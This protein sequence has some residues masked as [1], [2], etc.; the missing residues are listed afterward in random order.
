MT[1]EIL[2]VGTEILLGDIVNTNAAYIAKGLAECGIGCY[3]QT[4]VGDNPARLRKALDTALDRADAVIMTGGLGPT[5]YDL[6]KETAAD[7]FGLDMELHQP[8]YDHLLGMFRRFGR[9]MS[10]SNKK[11]AYMPKGAVVLH[12]DRGTANGLM[13]SGNGKTAILMPGPPREMTAMFDNFVKPYLRERSGAVLVSSSVHLFGIG[14]SAV[15]DMLKSFMESRSNPTV[16][17]YAKEGEVMLR[18]TASA[19]TGEEAQGMITPVIEEI[20][21]MLGEYIYGIDTGNLQ[22]ALVNTLAEKNLTI[23]V[24][25]SCTGGLVGKRITEVPGASGVFACC[26]CTYSNEM[27]TKLLGVSADV[28]N[29]YGAVSE[30]TAIE[31]AR[32]VRALSGADLGLSVTGI[33][34][35]GGGM[36]E[37]PVGLVYIAVSSSNGD[38]AKELRLS[39]GYGGEREHIR[40]LAS[41]NALHLALRS[42]AAQD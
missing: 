4:V 18:V 37:K 11:Q 36:P 10:E 39:R 41:S 31:M 5:Y 35:P 17:P 20:R 19:P 14:E 28:L 25:E 12:N 40:W 21:G 7:Y 30:Q 32:G 33:A 15:Q 6:T 1:A 29:T 23:A 3:Y 2:C 8:S 38:T 34:G 9:P 27:K 13:V 16:A 24:A 42:A 26:V 22:T